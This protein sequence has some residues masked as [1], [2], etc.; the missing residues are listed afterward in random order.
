MAAIVGV[1]LVD[2]LQRKTLRRERLLQPRSDHLLGLTDDEV[3]SRY[4]FKKHSIL[5]M[6]ALLQEKLQR[7]TKRSNSLPV[8]IQ[9]LIT[10][11]FLAGGPYYLVIA[12][13]FQVGEA[14]VC[15]VVKAVTRALCEL[16]PKVIALP[17]HEA[18]PRIYQAFYDKGCSATGRRPGIPGVSG[19]IDGCQIEIKKPSLNTHEYICRKGFPSINI[20]VLCGPDNM[21]YQASVRWP[22]SVHDAK[23]FSNSDLPRLYETGE[24]L[25]TRT[26]AHTH[27]WIWFSLTLKQ[28]QWLCR[29][30]RHDPRWF[31]LS[32]ATLHHETNWQATKQTRR[33]IQRVSDKD[34]RLH[35][36][37]IRHTQGSVRKHAQQDHD[38]S[39]Q[40]FNSFVLSLARTK[41]H[42]ISALGCSTTHIPEIQLQIEFFVW[43]KPVWFCTMLQRSA[44]I[45][46]IRWLK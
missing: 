24:C 12:D 40:A 8:Q 34:T 37:Y 23:M 44:E 11:R 32:V 7:P 4:R 3:F 17:S 22:G 6:C 20:Q 21:I 46:L 1:Q 42:Q 2:R 30:E 35:R 43:S 13:L 38:F 39:L 33:K 45:T 9:I 15:R 25:S 5:Q 31:G 10:L 28:M 19:C 27:P 18:L 16:S 29:R 26:H 14:T 41:C 36:V